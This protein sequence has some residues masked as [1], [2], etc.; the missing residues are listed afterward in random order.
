MR[1]HP[2]WRAPSSRSRYDLRA[3]AGDHR[4]GCE[5]RRDRARE[6]ESVLGVY[7]A[8][9]IGLRFTAAPWRLAFRRRDA[10]LHRPARRHAV[11]LTWLAGTASTRRIKAFVR[12]CRRSLDVAA[13]RAYRLINGLVLCATQMEAHVAAP[14][15]VRELAMLISALLVGCSSA[16]GP[17]RSTRWQRRQS[18]VPVPAAGC[19]RHSTAASA[20]LRLARVRRLGQTASAYARRRCVASSH[21]GDDA[22]AASGTDAAVDAGPPRP[23]HRA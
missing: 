23:K 5:E 2:E 13:A 8:S 10:G 17:R 19:R 1:R 7:M 15:V 16:G 14:I 12:L 4:H 6:G 22:G 21:S 20:T 3:R 11:S 9:L 18:A